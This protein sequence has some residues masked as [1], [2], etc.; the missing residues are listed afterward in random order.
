MTNNQ[1]PQVIMQ[2]EDYKETF[3]LLFKDF[4]ARCK[5]HQYEV[6][7]LAKEIECA[8]NYI[9]DKAFYKLIDM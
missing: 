5:I 7:E 4:I 8:F 1:R 9:S 6:N 2:Q 3:E